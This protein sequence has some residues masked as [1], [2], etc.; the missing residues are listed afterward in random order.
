MGQFQLASRTIV[1]PQHVMC[2]VSY[3]VRRQST[4]VTLEAV[5]PER[6]EIKMVIGYNVLNDP[7]IFATE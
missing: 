5:E 6:I 7:F 4:Q 3:C 2:W 1:I